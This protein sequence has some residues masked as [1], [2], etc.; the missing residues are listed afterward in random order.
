MAIA[1]Y[2]VTFRRRSACNTLSTLYLQD[3][4]DVGQQLMLTFTRSHH[5]LSI[6]RPSC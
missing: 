1:G 4:V 5:K 3:K 6:T 2:F